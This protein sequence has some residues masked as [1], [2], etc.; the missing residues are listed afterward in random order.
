[1]V[2]PYD[3]IQDGVGRGGVANRGIPNARL[4]VNMILALLTARS[5]TVSTSKRAAQIW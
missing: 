4:Q 1:M 2:V 5:F 3:A